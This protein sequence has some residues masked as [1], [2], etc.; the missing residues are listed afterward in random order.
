VLG[1]VDEG[2]ET[3]LAV[4]D[5]LF[6]MEGTELEDPR[7]PQS[8]PYSDEEIEDSEV[9]EGIHMSHQRRERQDTEV[10]ASLPVG[11]PWPAQLSSRAVLTSRP[12]QDGDSHP[13]DIAASIQAMAKSVH[14]SSMFG[15]NVFGELPQ[16]RTNTHRKN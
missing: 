3:A 7:S 12:P 10:A 13:R 15:D 5:D 8:L 9:D 4:T 1:Q 6:L 11:I 16:P 2:V 14:T